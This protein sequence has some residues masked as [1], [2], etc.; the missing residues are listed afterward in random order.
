MAAAAGQTSPSQSHGA[1]GGRPEL[2]RAC[3]GCAPEAMAAAAAAAAV[4]AGA[5]RGS[6]RSV[7]RAGWGGGC[8]RLW[9]LS[10]RS[11][12]AGASSGS[13]ALSPFDRRLKRKQKNW[14]ALQAEPAK[15]D[16]LREEVGAAAAASGPGRA[17][18]ARWGRLRRGGS[19]RGGV[20]GEGD[21][22]RR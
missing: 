16:Y 21:A 4:G 1:A 3:A 9:A 5:L 11:A 2:S 12:A 15:C 19:A 7:L 20:G 10:G 17:P 6:G 13:G 14:A 22:P 18:S 8:R